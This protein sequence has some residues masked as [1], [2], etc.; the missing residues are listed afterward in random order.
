MHAFPIVSNVDVNYE[1][2]EYEFFSK[3]SGIPKGYPSLP[4]SFLLRLLLIKLKSLIYS[5]T[6]FSARELTASMNRTMDP[7]RSGSTRRILRLA[8]VSEPHHSG[9]TAR[10]CIK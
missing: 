10:E 2:Y 8:E 7:L 6:L 4:S 5:L 3:T 1:S 9:R